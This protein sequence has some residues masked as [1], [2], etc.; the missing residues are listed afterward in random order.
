MSMGKK[1]KEMDFEE[2]NQLFEQNELG[3]A[4]EML[5]KLI[6]ENQSDI[7]LLLLRGR[8]YYKMQR[9]GDA[10]NDYAAVI[11]IEPQNHEAKVGIEMSKNI[12]GYFTPDMFNP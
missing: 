6:S 4:L 11:E 9:W 3:Q 2:V 10:M 12:L 1:K 7:G 8:I 5:D